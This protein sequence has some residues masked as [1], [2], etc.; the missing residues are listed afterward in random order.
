M[1]KGTNR[2]RKAILFHPE[3]GGEMFLPTCYSL[4]ELKGFYNPQDRMLKL[5][6]YF[7]N[8]YLP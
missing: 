6:G 2:S 8:S 3:Y 4:S 7:D 5:K 1:K